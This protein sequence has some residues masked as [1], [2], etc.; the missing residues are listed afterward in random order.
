MGLFGGLG[1]I[2]G[3]VTGVKVQ[4][5]KGKVKVGSPMQGLNIGDLLQMGMLAAPGGNLLSIFGKG[6]LGNLSM[7]NML[8][9]T[10]LQKLFSG[11]LG[12]MNTSDFLGLLGGAGGIGGLAGLL[13]G[14][15]TGGNGQPPGKTGGTSGALNQFE[16]LIQSIMPGAKE[17]AALLPQ[18]SRDRRMF[19]SQAV[20]QLSPG[21]MQSALD[22]GR[23]ELQGQAR[24]DAAQASLALGQNATGLKSGIQL[25][26]MNNAT[27]QAN[28]NEAD[29]FNP[30]NMAQISSAKLGFLDPSYHT[31]NLSMGLGGLNDYISLYNNLRAS[32]ANYSAS[33]PPSFLEQLL[34]IAP[35]IISAFEKK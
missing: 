1:N 15:G 4:P 11:G 13:G 14:G 16:S 23:A 17:E 26:A 25:G 21:A 2:L 28:Q 30:A 5:F 7:G 12:K 34:G 29:V 3:K 18:L 33:K 8:G 9:N 20:N 24:R 31:S 35:G 10:G 6:G 32:N 27:R 22:R 19:A